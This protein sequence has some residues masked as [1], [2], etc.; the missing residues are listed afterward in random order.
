MFLKIYFYTNIYIRVQ[1]HTTTRAPLIRPQTKGQT[2]HHA[3]WLT[4]RCAQFWQC[5]FC[6]KKQQKSW[7]LLLVGKWDGDA[8]C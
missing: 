5:L 8:F 6:N 4:K 1:Q 7:R 3:K 2:V